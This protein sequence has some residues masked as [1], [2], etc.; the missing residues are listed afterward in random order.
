VGRRAS[1]VHGSWRLTI[2]GS[3]RK[4]SRRSR[5]E[6]SSIVRAHHVVLHQGASD[7]PADEQAA[8]TTYEQVSNDAAAEVVDGDEENADAASVADEAKRR[9]V[10]LELYW[11]AK[12]FADALKAEPKARGYLIYYDDSE[13]PN[14][15]QVQEIVLREKERFAQKYGIDEWRVEVFYGGYSSAPLM[16]I[17]IGPENAQRPIPK[18]YPR[19]APDVA[20]ADDVKNRL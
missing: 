12:C 13:D 14:N 8:A 10:K 6:G 11:C 15:N 5:N 4:I 17:W 18:S 7:S 19:K 3:R 1:C 20:G 2:P 9:S 16:E